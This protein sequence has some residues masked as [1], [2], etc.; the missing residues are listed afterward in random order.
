MIFTIN[1]DNKKAAEL[2]NEI[3]NKLKKNDGVILVVKLEG[4][5]AD[6]VSD[7]NIVKIK[8]IGYELGYSY[9]SINKSKLN[10][11]DTEIQEN[12]IKTKELSTIEYEFL[13]K[14]GYNDQEIKIARYLIDSLGESTDDIKKEVEKLFYSH[15]NLED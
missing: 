8:Q 11:I 1:A 7:I 4:Q 13:K 9:I 2:E 3:I 6:K 5:L 12:E 10:D 15:D 14:K